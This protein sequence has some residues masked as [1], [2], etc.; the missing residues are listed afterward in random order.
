[1][2][3][4]NGEEQN[5]YTFEVKKFMIILCYEHLQRPGYL[6]HFVKGDEVGNDTSN[7]T[8]LFWLN[9]GTKTAAGVIMTD[10]NNK[11]LIC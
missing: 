11:T 7:C 5:V 6:V 3:N 10:D 4:A 2:Y 9:H 1:M 8:E